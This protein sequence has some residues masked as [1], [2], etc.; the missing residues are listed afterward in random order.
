[1]AQHNVYEFYAE[2][3]GF[4]PKI[5]R[6][7]QISGNKTMAE[8]GYTLMIMFEMQA[9][10][11]FCFRENRLEAL[12][13]DLKS[14]YSEEYIKSVL[15]KSSMN[16]ITNNVKYELPSEAMF[17]DDDEDLVE[18]NQIN[19]NQLT[20]R[21]DWKLEFQYDYG[22]NWEIDVTLNSVEKQEISLSLLPRVLEGKGF[23]IIEDVGGVGGLDEFSKAMKKG[24]GTSYNEYC[25]WLGITSF[26][27]NAFDIDDINF[28]LKKLVRVYRDIYEYEYEPTKKSMD[29]LL[30][31]Y[32]E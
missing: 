21:K 11:L 3:N 31:K 20:D 26:D 6:K 28:R 23:G 22:D 7:F 27:I 14:K 32:K 17:L 8:L 10:H 16:S 30:R 2:L 4:T 13:D 12:F 29:I 25:D 19:L 1:M 5:W 15:E 18:A 24:K 9:S